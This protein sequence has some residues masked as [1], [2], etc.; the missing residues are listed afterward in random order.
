TSIRMLGDILWMTQPLLAVMRGGKLVSPKITLPK[1]ARIQP[2]MTLYLRLH[3]LL[4]GLHEFISHLHHHLKREVRLF[5]CQHDRVQIRLVAG[6]GLQ[7]P[8]GRRLEIVH[9]LDSVFQQTSE[10]CR[11]VSRWLDT[12]RLRHYARDIVVDRE[13]AHLPNSSVR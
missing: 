12:C 2:G 1:T 13:I 5:K 11:L 10:G 8:L 3:D 6:E 7:F 4:V 9:L